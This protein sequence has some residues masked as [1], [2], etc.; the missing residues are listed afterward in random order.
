MKNESDYPAEY[1]FDA[2]VIGSIKGAPW[3][4][5]TEEKDEQ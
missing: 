1:Y 4:L 2:E 5:F 3:V